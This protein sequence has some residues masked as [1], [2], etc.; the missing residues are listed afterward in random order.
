MPKHDTRFYIRQITPGNTRLYALQ[1]FPI[2]VYTG[3]KHKRLWQDVDDSNYD[4]AK[5][6]ID[7]VRELYQDNKFELVR[8]DTRTTTVDESNPSQDTDPHR[9]TEHLDA[10]LN[11]YQTILQER[12]ERLDHDI[13]AEKQSLDNHRLNGLAPIALEKL[14]SHDEGMKRAYQSAL[15]LINAVDFIRS[16]EKDGK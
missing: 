9:S 4:H 8:I 6:I 7:K 13:E 2:I 15:S 10:Q 12:L 3:Q 1:T 14:I 16:R 11:E 5:G